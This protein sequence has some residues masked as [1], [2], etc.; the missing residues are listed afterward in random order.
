SSPVFNAI[1][2]YGNNKSAIFIDT[3]YS[4][5][6]LHERNVIGMNKKG[7]SR[8]RHFQPRV[9]RFFYQYKE[10]EKIS[11]LLIINLILYVRL[12]WIRSKIIHKFNLN[13]KLNLYKISKNTK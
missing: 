8:K 5:Y 4:Q 10:I 12:P 13:N 11:Y 9:S 7:K 3:P 6:R 2:L 1:D